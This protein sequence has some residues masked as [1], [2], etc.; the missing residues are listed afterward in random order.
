MPDNYKLFSEFP[1][2]STPDWEKKIIQDLKGRDYNKKLIWKTNEGFEVRPYYREEDLKSLN[3]LADIHYE[4]AKLCNKNSNGNKWLIRQD[5]LVYDADTANRKALEIL[6]KGITSLGFV[7]T[8]KVNIDQTTIEKLLNG[9]CLTAV[10]LNFICESR[11]VEFITLFADYVVKKGYNPDKIFGS[12]NLDT[13]G[14]LIKYGTFGQSNDEA[15]EKVIKSGKLLKTFPHFKTITVHG[16]YFTNAGSSIVQSLAYSLAIASDYLSWLTEA[17]IKVSDAADN[18][19]FNFAISSDYFMEIAHLRAARLLWSKIV[20]SY[21]AKCSVIMDIY[22]ETGKWNKTVYDPYVNIL[23]ST[24]EA[25]SAALGGV[26]SLSIGPFDLTYE[27]PVDLA[28]RIA[29]NIQIILQ[30]ESYFDKT[31]D[32]AAGSY[33]IENLTDSIIKSVWTLFLD[34]QERGGFVAAFRKGFIQ[35]SIKAMADK[36]INAIATRRETLLGTNQFP[37]FNEI[38]DHDIID[39][40][41]STYFEGKNNGKLTELIAEPLKFF[42]GSEGFE[43]LRQITDRA[44]SRPKVFMLTTGNLAMRKA[45]ATFAC[46]FFA[47]AGFQVIDNDGF[48]NTDEGIKAAMEVK[49]DIIVLCS[50]DEEYSSIAPEA[51]AKT[52]NK[53]IF[54]VA[55]DPPCKPDLQAKGINNFISVKSNVLETL[56]YYQQLLNMITNN[57]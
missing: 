10:E 40:S 17:G 15:L 55:G 57:E 44:A 3:Y 12:I 38:I 43:E 33:Y 41:Y 49:S 47:C 7:I 25:M 13:V 5:I 2:V 53:V 6:N 46:N 1:P 23:R 27:V 14:Y 39:L 21:D 29:R 36:K 8:S 24:T 22:S 20:E 26:S 31:I 9:L 51:F 37:N 35:Q 18:I 11:E 30:E 54:V 16:T 34:V 50:G 28:E 56:K 32:P 42:R 52:D 19:K 48:I 45:R 4:I